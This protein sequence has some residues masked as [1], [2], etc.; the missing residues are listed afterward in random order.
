MTTMAAMKVAAE[1]IEAAGS[2]AV[3]SNAQI[4]PAESPGT[5]TV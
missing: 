3:P 2:S 4:H 5:L 1:V